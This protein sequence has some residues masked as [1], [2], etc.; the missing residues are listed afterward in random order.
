MKAAPGTGMALYVKDITSVQGAT[1]RLFT[2]LDGSSGT[3]LWKGALAA[4]DAKTLTFDVP[5]KCTSATG[6]YL[7]SAGASA[8]AMLLIGG[9]TARG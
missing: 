2:L 9:F 7:T 1:S 5:L 6:L 3:V 8:N 4:N